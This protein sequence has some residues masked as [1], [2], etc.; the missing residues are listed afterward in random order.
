[1]VWLTWQQNILQ[2]TRHTTSKFVAT[3]TCSVCGY[4]PS[5]DDTE[6]ANDYKYREVEIDGTEV[7]VPANCVLDVPFTTYKPF[8][9]KSVTILGWNSDGGIV[10]NG[11]GYLVSDDGTLDAVEK[12]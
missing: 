12:D 10:W 6:G 3:K 9:K 4:G 7:Y 1:M 8:N 5:Y 2:Q 11:N